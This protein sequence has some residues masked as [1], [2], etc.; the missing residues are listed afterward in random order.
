MFDEPKQ[1]SFQNFEGVQVRQSIPEHVSRKSSLIKYKHLLKLAEL[2]IEICQNLIAKFKQGTKP[3]ESIIRW[4][5]S[6]TKNLHNRDRY[7]N[8]L[9]ELG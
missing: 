9:N 6:L 1:K 7:L 3:D 5:N 8:K 2:N 4:E